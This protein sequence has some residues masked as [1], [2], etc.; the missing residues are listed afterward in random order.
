M[1]RA[2]ASRVR[3]W[4]ATL[5]AA[6]AP[7]KDRVGL[8]HASVLQAADDTQHRGGKSAVNP[9]SMPRSGG[10]PKRTG[11]CLHS[12]YARSTGEC[13]TPCCMFSREFTLADH[14]R[15]FTVAPSD[16]ADGS[17]S[18]TQDRA[19][20]RR[21]LFSDWHRVERAMT[22]IDQR[23]VGIDVEGLAGDR[24]G[25]R[26]RATRRIDSRARRPFRSGVR[27]C[28]AWRAGGRRGRPPT[29]SR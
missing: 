13:G 28:R 2:C 20:V 24:S 6:A 15:R 7:E 12:V 3:G 29:A 5:H 9:I 11:I 10:C 26:R 14:S 1:T 17:C 19:V 8:G 16:A 25:R 18:V 22:A 27:P 4:H 23:N 21:T